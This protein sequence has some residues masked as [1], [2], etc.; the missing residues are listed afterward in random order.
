M[1]ETEI[2]L[3]QNGGN[4]IASGGFGCIFKPALKCENDTN[5]PTNKISKLMS[6]K[7]ATDEY[8]QIQKFKSILQ[9]I[10][11]YQHYFLFDGITLCK[12]DVLTKKDLKYYN[13]KCKAL[14]KKNIMSKNI[15]NSLDQILSLNI[16]D[17][18]IDVENFINDYFVSSDIVLLNN[19]L[20]DLLVNGIVP[21]NNLHVFHCDIKDG[22][23]L[24][25]MTETSLESRLIDWGLSFIH[26]E[27]DG[28]PKKI[29]RRP[30]QFNVPFS[31]VL[32][33][34]EFV[35]RYYQFLEVNKEPNYFQIREFVINY[36]FIWNDIR[37]PGHL[38]GINDIMK[39]LYGNE[40]TSI[41]KKKVKQHVIEYDFT[42]YY[43]VEYLSKILEKY[44][45]NGD[46]NMMQ[47]FNTVFLKNVDIWGF[48]MIY[49]VLYEKFYDKINELT[50]YQLLFI[51]K[52]KY[53]IIHFLYES[54]VDPININDLVNELTN[55]NQIASKF[56]TELGGK[57]KN[58]KYKHKKTRKNNTKK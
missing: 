13:K 52:I 1:N 39:K 40:L 38:N 41:K 30:F 17:G 14:T 37:G 43:I 31:S 32:F 47:Y 9:T 34:K 7:N 22:N 8:N 48:V 58:R 57:I 33:N 49:I 54:P 55:L 20:I 26:N 21:M 50:E 53:I 5:R 35:K 46:F 3:D 42:Y 12:P 19:S 45:Y 44:T 27:N 25:K 24:V 10:P 28:I 15:N 11:K 23:V 4:V 36:I 56:N 6:I 18:G 2:N 51:N 16:P 29:Y